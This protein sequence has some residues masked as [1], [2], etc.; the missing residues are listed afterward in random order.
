M[1]TFAE[2]IF[3][4]S[5]VMHTVQPGESYYKISL[6][7]DVDLNELLSLNGVDNPFVCVGQLIK[8]KPVYD[9]KNISVQVNGATI[10]M[11]SPCYIE[12]DMVFAPV[13]FVAE[14]LGANVDWDNEIKAAVIS[15]NGKVIKLT[16]GSRFVEVD[17]SIF[18]AGFVIN[19]LN[20][21]VYI[22]LR[23]VAENLGCGLSWDPAEYIAVIDTN[24]Q[25][26]KEIIPV[27][28]YSYSYSDEDLYWLSRIVE[29]EANGEPYEGKLAVANVVI[30]RKNSPDFPDT[31]KDVIF[32]P[33]YGYQF[34]PVKNG[35]IYN[36]PSQ[37]SIRAAREAL[38]G[39]NNA[40]G[41]LYFLNPAKSGYTWIQANRI[42]F[43]IIGG[44]Y[45]YL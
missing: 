15:S 37:D 11:D 36:E 21:R 22:P 27:S 6:K 35:S 32:D 38:E 43:A 26:Q 10:E 25:V 4:S 45:F 24:V 39:N 41:S 9:N 42:L 29:A 40:G 8:V 31:I 7:Y 17:G 1:V 16:P 20:G 19:N 3:A 12:R 13:R 33:S 5:Y 44:H 30:N 34:T 23:F 14:G 2:P 18:D 28:S